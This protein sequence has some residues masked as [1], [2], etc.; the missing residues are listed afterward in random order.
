MVAYGGASQ[1]R[2]ASDA[3]GSPRG[4]LRMSWRGGDAWV[5]F[6]R[7]GLVT[8]SC[9]RDAR[10]C[11][12]GHWAGARCMHPAATFLHPTTPRGATAVRYQIGPSTVLLAMAGC[13]VQPGCSP[14]G[15]LRP[16]AV[17]AA[18]I[19]ECTV[20][21]SGAGLFQLFRPRLRALLVV[22]LLVSL[23]TAS[24]LIEPWIYRAIIDDIAGV[25]VAP[26]RSNRPSALADVTHRCGTSPEVSGGSLP[27]RCRSSLAPR[28]SAGRSSWAHRRRRWPPCSSG[29][30]SW[31]WSSVRRSG[32]GWAARFA[33]RRWRTASN[34]VHPADVPACL[35]VAARAFSRG[36]RAG[37]R[38]PG[39]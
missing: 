4:Q 20:T 30:C 14:A 28:T 19:C 39:R 3:A 7:T 24:S 33:R 32:A 5:L 6:R 21:T 10:D 17:A 23:S 34:A 38:P 8:I 35:R 15:P 11:A 29:R 9:D 37:G 16:A 22:A 36:E 13:S 2:T 26:P 27:R 1:I 31:Y 25:F 12:R 18:T